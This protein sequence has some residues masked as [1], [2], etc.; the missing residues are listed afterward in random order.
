MLS[1]NASSQLSE[2][3]NKSQTEL[4]ISNLNKDNSF[5]M[6]SNNDFEGVR[7]EI[8]INNLSQIEIIKIDSESLIIQSFIEVELEGVEVSIDKKYLGRRMFVFV[9]F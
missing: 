8:I 7:V 2:D 3:L 1:I 5:K 4:I 6:S 9:K